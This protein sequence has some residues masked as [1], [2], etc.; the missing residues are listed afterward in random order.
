MDV[1]GRDVTRWLRLLLRKEGADLHRTSEFEIVREI[2]EQA[3]FLAA[4]AAKEETLD[5]EKVDYIVFL[6]SLFSTIINY[7]MALGWN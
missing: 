3:C 7:L 6:F 4:N 5:N 1:A 2:K